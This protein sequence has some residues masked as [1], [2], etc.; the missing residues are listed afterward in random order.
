MLY[1]HPAIQEAVIIARK[2]P[3]RGETV[4]GGRRAQAVGAR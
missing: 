1:S 2:D 4:K 3:R